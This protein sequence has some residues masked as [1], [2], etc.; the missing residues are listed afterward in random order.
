MNCKTLALI[1]SKLR[2]T[3]IIGK[4]EPSIFFGVYEITYGI[5]DIIWKSVTNQPLFWQTN[6]FLCFY[7]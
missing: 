4:L 2:T 7:N 1:V 5:R 6:E 3:I